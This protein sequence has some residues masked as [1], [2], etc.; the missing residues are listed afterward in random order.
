MPLHSGSEQMIVICNGETLG[1]GCQLLRVL[2]SL[3]MSIS[4]AMTMAGIFGDLTKWLL[5]AI[6]GK[7]L[8]SVLGCGSGIFE[9]A[10]F[11]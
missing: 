9:G 7:L 3:T 10:V 5:L 4:R 8:C 11:R 6:V 1:D 2:K